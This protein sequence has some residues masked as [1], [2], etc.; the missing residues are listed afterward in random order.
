MDYHKPL[1]LLHAAEE[2]IWLNKINQARGDGRLCNWV[3]GLHPQ[4]LSC[5][6]LVDCHNGSYNFIQGLIFENET[7]WFLRLPRASS[8]APEYADEK[9][10]MEVEAL[11][12]IRERSSIPVPEIYAWGLAKDNQ[13]GLGPYI[14]MEAIDGVSLRDVFSTK[15]SRLLRQE[16]TDTDVEYVYRQMAQ[17]MLQLF[18]IDFD[19]IGNL[20]TPRTKY[21]APR[22]PLTWKAHDILRLGGVNA[23]GSFSTRPPGLY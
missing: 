19:K 12:L 8:I 9:V 13:L 18:Q 17:I 23:F 14:L 4:K 11:S 7:V 15:D 20:P 5:K 6:L 16:I 1:D 2:K 3:T 10:A 21:A 22:R